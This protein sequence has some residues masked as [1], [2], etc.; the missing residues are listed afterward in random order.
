MNEIIFA[1][2]QIGETNGALYFTLETDAKI[3]RYKFIQNKWLTENLVAVHPYG[4]IIIKYPEV[5]APSEIYAHIIS[6]MG[7]IELEYDE[8]IYKMTG[9]IVYPSLGATYTFKV[10]QPTPDETPVNDIAILNLNN[11][12]YENYT[13]TFSKDNFQYAIENSVVVNA[14]LAFSFIL[15]GAIHNITGSYDGEPVIFDRMDDH[16]TAVFIAG[17]EG[18]HEL[19]AMVDDLYRYTITI[20]VVGSP[21]LITNIEL[22][23]EEGEPRSIPLTPNFTPSATEYAGVLVGGVNTFNYGVI[24]TKSPSTSVYASVSLD[25]GESRVIY[26]ESAG[27]DKIYFPFSAPLAS[28]SVTIEAMGDYS[29]IYT[30]SLTQ[31]NPISVINDVELSYNGNAIELTPTFNDTNNEYTCNFSDYENIDMTVNIS[32][33]NVTTLEAT[34]YGNPVSVTRDFDTCTA[35]LP[36][37]ARTAE[38]VIT[39]YADGREHLR[40]I[41]ITIMPEY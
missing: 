35:S 31:A 20:P 37:E 10:A 14:D 22:E 17:S 11:G 40:T 32:A 6:A 33:E 38:L 1:I 13:P 9:D 7:N 19:T 5:N 4:A 25:G 3:S 15:E 34:L 2:N 12:Q 23:T 30:L 27:D 41:T 28:A 21:S 36:Y 8:K 29:I 39:A 16:Y 18:T 24:V 26:G